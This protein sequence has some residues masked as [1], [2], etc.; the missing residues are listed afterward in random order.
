V[1]LPPSNNQPSL[2]FFFLFYNVNH[3][4]F[5]HLILTVLPVVSLCNSLQ[6]E[7]LHVHCRCS[8]LHKEISAP[9]IIPSVRALTSAGTPP[10]FWTKPH[11]LWAFWCSTMQNCF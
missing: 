11:S 3:S 8:D 6:H 2:V 9:V 7:W 1:C 5:V 4:I 10:T